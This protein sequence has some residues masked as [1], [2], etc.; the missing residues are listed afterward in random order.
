MAHVTYPLFTLKGGGHGRSLLVSRLFLDGLHVWLR[1]SPWFAWVIMKRFIACILLCCY[2]NLSHAATAP[3]YTGGINN[4]IGSIL[5]SKLAK[6]AALGPEYDAQFQRTMGSITNG[7]TASATTLVAG[8]LAA[9]VGAISWP[10][11]LVAAG[12]NGVVSGAVSLGMDGLIKWL[13]PDS[14][15]PNQVQ[16][17]GAGMT[18]QAPVYSNGIA[19]GQTAWQTCGGSWGSPQEALSYCF[20]TTI[21]QYPTATYSVPTLTQ[22]SSSQYTA[23]YT[24]SIPPLGLNNQAGTKTVSAVAYSGITCPAGSGY[25]SGSTCTSAGLN[26]GPYSTYQAYWQSIGQAINA[27]PESQ[28]TVAL[29]DDQLA[30]IANAVW[31]NAPATNP[32]GSTFN[33]NLTNPITAA[34]IAAWRAANPNLAPSVKDFIGPVAAPGAS[35]VPLAVPN[36]TVTP[37]PAPT[38]APGTT[39]APAEIDWGSFNEP[40]LDATPTTESILDPIFNMWPQWNGFAFPAH[41]SQCPTPTFVALNHTFTFDHMCTWVEMIRSGVQ[42]AFALVWA[43]AVVLIVMGA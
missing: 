26:V 32:A 5:N 35:T 13:W 18:S 43:L 37:A 1:I 40:T 30:A 41:T 17:S 25:V 15:H 24:Y 4:T 7:L 8:G 34:D 21:A 12:V 3:A 19:A 9:S 29:S 23:T 39:T 31:K 36:T 33:F 27:L 16:L 38:P 11:L 14:S 10:A 20:S 42:A 22:N 6:T 28:K 2:F